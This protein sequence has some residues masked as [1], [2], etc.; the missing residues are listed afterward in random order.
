MYLLKDDSIRIDIN[1]TKAKELVDQNGNLREI[2][3]NSYDFVYM[4][5]AVRISDEGFYQCAYK[6]DGLSEP[7]LS[8]KM[9][10]TVTGNLFISISI[11][12]IN[13]RLF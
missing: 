2:C 10:L 11:N 12:L 8:L 13:T 7:V 4:F 1:R 5:P 6:P 9:K 3:Q